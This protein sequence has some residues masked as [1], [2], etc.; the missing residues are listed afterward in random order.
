[1]DTLSFNGDV[2]RDLRAAASREW[3][4][5]NGLG[6]Y[7]SSTIVG[8]NTRRYHGLLV[9]APPPLAER[10]VLLARVEET[11][12]TGD[13][14]IELAT[15]RYPGII[16]PQGF[17]YLKSF[18]LDPFPTFVYDIDGVEVEKTLFM[19][20]GENTT[21]IQYAITHHDGAAAPRLRLDVRPLIAF[22]DYHSTTHENGALNA[23]VIVGDG[24]AT[25]APYAGLPPLHLA[26]NAV[27]LQK[28]GY[29]YRQCEL[30]AERERGLDSIEDHFNPFTL[31]FEIGPGAPAV[32]VASTEPQN[33]SRAADC[34][35]REITRRH[36]IVTPTT[37]DTPLTRR[38][39]RAADDYIVR[40]GDR[41]TIVAG[42]HW[43]TDWG[44]DAMIALTGLTLVTGKY[45]VARS[46]LRAFASHV[47][48]GMLPNRFPDRGDAPEYNTVDATLWMFEAARAYVQYSSDFGFVSTELYPVLADIVSWHLRGTRYGIKVD[49]DGLLTSGA[50][51]VQ[52]TWM[53][54]KVGDRVVTPRHG[55]PVEIQALWYNA[56]RVMEDFAG[57]AGDRD[58]E[59]RYHALART[60]KTAFNR[61]FWNGASRCLFDVVNGDAKDGAIRP[62]QIFAVSLPHSMLSQARAADVVTTV[63]MHL[64]TP[65]GLRTLAPNDPEYHGRYSGGPAER[66][67]A[68]HQ[69]TV[70]PWL[71]G[72]F[73]TAY[74]RVHRSSASARA[75]ARRWLA[76]LADHL[77]QA[78]VGHISEIFEG[79]AP[80]GPCGCIAQAWSVAEI[81][82]A[83][84]EDVMAP[85]ARRSRQPIE[86]RTA[87]RPSA[88]A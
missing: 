52:L 50:D 64:L 33:V 25:V 66:D 23:D 12:H 79:D 18:H 58:G 71:L 9:A 38:L 69:G 80:H 51:G 29:W 83:C 35:Q 54:A 32:I 3:L 59:H 21:V 49:A 20:H 4:E 63:W 88:R 75:Q 55:K 48:Q 44:R 60:V 87:A 24:M 40:R 5:T 26:H 41:Q 62:N 1:M 16:H 2:C 36:R 30:D 43:F 82:R 39:A 34:R 27:D 6:G 7:A 65:L 77:S 86:L 47:D 56:L 68:Y 13:A 84:V 85:P 53:D 67:A 14:A 70:W 42:Y 72:P 11:L 31:R 81:L 37:F 45:D 28:T 46:V 10:F 76:P 61:T 17:R 57:R 22:R 73:V 78:G 74:V 19:V 8:L 15:S